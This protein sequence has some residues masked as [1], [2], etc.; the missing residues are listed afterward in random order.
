MSKKF[1]FDKQAYF[2]KIGYQPHERQQAFHNST[3]RF[4]TVVA[5]RRGG[6]SMSSAR[7]FEPM[8]FMPNKVIWLVGQSYVLGEKEFRVIWNDVMVKLGFMNQPNVRKSYNLQQGNMFIELLDLNTQLHV[9]SAERDEN[10]VG[11]SLD[12]VLL[13]EASKLRPRTWTQFIEPALSDK[14]GKAIVS[15]TPHGRD[16]VYD[17]FMKGLDAN[18]P[19]YA[20]FHFPSWSNN[21]IYP[22]GY[23]D[24]EIQRMKRSMPEDVFNQEIGADFASFSGRIFKEF[25]ET[26]HVRNH[27]FRPDWPNFVSIDFGWNYFAAIEFQVSPQDT[28]HI[29]REHFEQHLTLDEHFDIM[30]SREQPK[31]YHINLCFGDPADPEGI[32]QTSVKFAPCVGKMEAKQNVREGIDVVKSFL[33]LRPD[34]TITI[35]TNQDDSAK[36][37]S[38]VLS[39]EPGL[40]VDPSCRHTIREFN[41]YEFKDP[42]RQTDVQDAPKKKDDHCMDSIRYGLMHIFKLGAN[43]HL[44]EIYDSI[45][46]V[47]NKH[48]QANLTRQEPNDNFGAT[49]DHFPSLEQAGFIQ[50]SNSGPQF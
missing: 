11:E 34:T 28:V 24:P 4:K 3:A 35:P 39:G 42:V 6:K 8:L 44:T 14:R 5:G 36:E 22:L 9:K 21:I 12:A 10:L 41:N 33:N 2:T 47:S 16:F 40:F 50:L 26:T 45:H 20:S 18:E 46:K 43:R 30:R 31:G 27:E 19:E 49:M 37:L 7:E 48:N 13:C 25:S 1:A 29:W 32:K 17:L 23:D 38:I 15:T